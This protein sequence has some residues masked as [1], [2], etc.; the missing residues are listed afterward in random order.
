MVSSPVM[1]PGGGHTQ[2]RHLPDLKISNI[3]GSPSALY[4]KPGLTFG[5][6]FRAFFPCDTLI[7]QFTASNRPL[8]RQN[9]LIV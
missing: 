5:V 2:A 8:N 3:A 4:T 6:N 7:A 9:V 1:R